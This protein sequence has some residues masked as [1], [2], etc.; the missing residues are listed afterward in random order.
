M[1]PNEL[2]DY[3]ASIRHINTYKAPPQ[4]FDTLADDILSKVYV[5]VASAMPLSAPP[6]GY[7]DGLADS[8]LQKIKGTQKSEAQQE[9]EDADPFLASLPK[10]N[11]YTVPQGYFETFTVPVATAKPAPVMKMTRRSPARWITYA[12]A[13]V[14]TGVVA[15]GAVL[16]AVQNNG[17]SSS[18]ET[19]A[20]V[21]KVSDSNLADYLNSSVPDADVAPASNTRELNSN[22]LY[23][24]LLNNVSDN[25][26]QQY[27]NE[28]DDSNEKT[29]TGI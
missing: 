16:F 7:F 4:Y 23:H 13:A 21:S 25:D 9:L 5:P 14:I 22:G 10:T 15:T 2:P 12:A 19:Q 18:K 11:P 29:T 8:I 26:I 17:V 24:Q 20:A 3:L 1:E 28:N 27:L 6:A